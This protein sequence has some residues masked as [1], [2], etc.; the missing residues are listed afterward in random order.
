MGGSASTD[1]KRK[2]DTHTDSTGV[3]LPPGWA[4]ATDKD[5]RKYYFNRDTGQT[6][7]E[8][9]AGSEEVQPDPSVDGTGCEVTFEKPMKYRASGDSGEIEVHRETVLHTFAIDPVI[10]EQ[11]AAGAR[12]MVCC[13]SCCPWHSTGNLCM[14][15]CGQF[16]YGLLGPLCICLVSQVYIVKCHFCCSSEG[17]R[18]ADCPPCLHY[19]AVKQPLPAFHEHALVVT[20]VGVRGYYDRFTMTW[21]PHACLLMHYHSL[22]VCAGTLLTWTASPLQRTFVYSYCKLVFLISSH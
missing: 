1:P 5:G 2:S 11:Y 21:W 10:W 8:P 12:H 22:Y 3:I 14:F 20:S 6:Q 19:S 9:P 17:P 16:V 7:F 18:L 13:T 15:P 4:T